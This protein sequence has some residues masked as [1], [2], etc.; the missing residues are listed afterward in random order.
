MIDIGNTLTSLAVIEDC[1]VCDLTKCKGAC[2]IEGDAGAP[3]TDIEA[4]YIQAQMPLIRPFLRPEG[5]KAIDEH[6]VS[7]LDSD[8]DRVTTLIND[9]EC[10]FVI[11]ENDVVKCGIEKAY[12]AGVINFKKPISCHLYPIRIDKFQKYD[13]LNYHRWDICRDAC[14]KGK[15]LRV[16]VYE[17]LKEP[18]IR[19]YGED[20]YNELSNIAAEYRKRY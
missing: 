15:E 14:L 20:W 3:V 1:F 10:A 12:E 16:K 18:L 11:Y 9:K 7:Y 2:C 6:G 8:G 13:A 17:F 4:Q 19:A 5:Q